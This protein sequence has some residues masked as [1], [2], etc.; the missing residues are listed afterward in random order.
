MS[1]QPVI[2]LPPSIP[3]PQTVVSLLQHQGIKPKVSGVL[4][5]EKPVIQ[6]HMSRSVMIDSFTLS[7]S[8]GP[9]TTLTDKEYPFLPNS[10]LAALNSL[11]KYNRFG[12]A[13]PQAVYFAHSI[14]W[15]AKA[16]YKIWAV[17]AP[18]AVGR[19]R[20]VYRPPM[21]FADSNVY[22]DAQRDIMTE[23]DFSSGNCFRYSLNGYNMRDFRN[24]L[25]TASPNS[26]IDR[27]IH[28]PLND[29]KFGYVKVAVT[30]RYQPGGIFPESAYFYLFQ[31]F[32]DI[33][34][35]IMRAPPMLREESALTTLFNSE[36]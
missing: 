15:N 27:N 10:G 13:Y 22:D 7:T 14:Y 34:F 11:V 32:S 35:K 18:A 33:Q 23:W 25:A 31:S 2:D 24:T 1:T 30:N 6:L 21:P 3:P 26:Q 20:V 9:G 36:L 19:L 16:D 28:I 4:P 29:Y 12:I 5:G 17:K 8:N